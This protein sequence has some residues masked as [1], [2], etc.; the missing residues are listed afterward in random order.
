MVSGK[1]LTNKQRIDAAIKAWKTK[2]LKKKAAGIPTKELKDML[3][4]DGFE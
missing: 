4:V 3:K 1:V 2:R